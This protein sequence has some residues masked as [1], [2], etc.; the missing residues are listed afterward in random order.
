MIRT[1]K[2]ASIAMGILALAM[3]A[4]AAESGSATGTVESLDTQA[5]SLVMTRGD[6]QTEVTL[7]ENCQIFREESADESAIEEGRH[8]EVNGKLSEDKTSFE[9]G[10]IKVYVPKGRGFEMLAPTRLDGKI[11]LRDG[12]L[13]VTAK[14]QEIAIEKADKMNVRTRT[15]VQVEDIVEG[16]KGMCYGTKTDDGI[17]ARLLTFMVD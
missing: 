15:W 17:E 7:H 8:V 3:L 6:S 12:N 11:S 4:H 16:K 9:A 1:V 2:I 5:R 14:G 13:Y 10:T